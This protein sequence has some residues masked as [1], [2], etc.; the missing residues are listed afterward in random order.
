MN[1]IQKFLNEQ[2]LMVLD[3]ALATELEGK[4]L[5]L[6]DDLWSAKVLAEQPD[7]IEQV[8]YEYFLA[9]ADVATT[10]SYQASVE[11]FV[12][13]GYTEEEAKQFIRQSVQ[14]A[15]KARDRFWQEPQNRAGRVRPL[16]AGSVGPYGAY[17]ADGSEYRGDYTISENQLADFHRQR[18]ALLIEAGADFLVCET[19]PCLWE[20]QVM[21]KVVGEFPGVCCWISFS[22]NSENTVCDGTSVEVCA[23]AMDV[24]P[25]VAAIGI[26]CTAPHLIPSLLDGMRSATQKPLAVYP[27]SGEVYDPVSK[28]WHGTGEAGA[29]A[30][31]SRLWH[32]HGASLIGG[33]CR[34]TPA[35]I[36]QVYSWVSEQRKAL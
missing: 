15:A 21:A 25:Q 18:M 32:A 10:A 12:K 3:G 20:A 28:T 2:K 33:C 13:K 17:L 9:G 4:G 30:A 8:H 14:I 7:V 6:N 19:V 29:F 35:H 23:A 5:D 34:T 36:A 24:Y 22:C 11:G 16:I 26:N 31:A 1:T 27:N